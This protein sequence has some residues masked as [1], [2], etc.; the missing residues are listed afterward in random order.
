VIA[1][2]EVSS[3]LVEGKTHLILIIIVKEEE[4]EEET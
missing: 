2:T 3:C 1:I 4:E